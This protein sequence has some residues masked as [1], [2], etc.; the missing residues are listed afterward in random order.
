MKRTAPSPAQS[1]GLTS[2][3]A[4]KRLA[5]YGDNTIYKKKRLRPIVVFLEKFNSPLLIILIV[6]A[7]IAFFLGERVNSIIILLMVVLSAILDFVNSY[8]SEKAV[9]RLTSR[10]ATS[11]TVVRDGIPQE[12]DFSLLVPGDVIFLSAGDVVPADA[13][14]TQA[15]DF[16][17]NQATLTGE[18]FP[19]EKHPLS[20]TDHP[21]IFMG[22]SVVTGTATATVVMTG[23]MTEFGK[24]AKRLSQEAPESSFDTA[25][26]NFSYF[27]MKVTIVLVLLVFLIHIFLGH[28][29]FTT[30][31]FAVAIAV[32][33]TPE[34]LPVIISVSLSRG[35]MIMAKKDVIVK[36]LPAIQNF[37]SMNVLC[38]D[39]T[40]TLTEDKIVMVNYLDTFGEVY[41]PIL[42][43]SYITTALHSGIRSP[44]DTAIA[45]HKQFDIS[46]YTKIDEIPFDFERKRGSLVIEHDSKGILVT[47]GTPEDVL[48]ISTACER[49]G[50]NCAFSPDL[51]RAAHERYQQLSAEGYR[52]LA[53]ATREITLTEEVY[54]KDAEH[55]MTFLGFIIFLDPP[56]ATAAE[57]VR[58]LHELGVEIKI[59]TGDSD[60]LTKKIC[61]DIGL[62]VRGI[63]TGTDVAQMNDAELM[64][65]AT[66]T[67]IFARINPEQKERII[68]ALKRGGAV[69]GYL[70]DGIND[71][72]A[73]RAADV[74]ISVNNAVDVAKETASIILLRKSLRAL[75]DGVIEGRKTFHNTTKYILMGLSSNFGNMLSMTAVSLFI[76][77]LPMLPAQILLNNFLYDSSQITLPTDT[78]DATDIRMP[79]K[80]D[81]HF[82]KRFMLVFGL[83][84]TFFDFITFGFLFFVFKL[85]ESQFQTGWFIESLATQ[86]F[87]IYIIRTKKIPFLESAPG[88]LLFATTFAAVLIGWI[89]P[90]T[91]LG[92]Y[93]L[94]ESLPLQVI[95]GIVS[96]AVVYLIAVEFA[97][98]IFYRRMAAT[99]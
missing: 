57:A 68:L 77:F 6:A 23:S 90:F 58:D 99:S 60:I 51:V 27:I 45:E 18:S 69:V 98:R 93:F 73:L 81:I 17:V 8:R 61:L 62:P 13:E 22:T 87:V 53:V 11:A 33:I 46:A 56:K 74:S 80:W 96:I 21:I 15:E 70:G 24:I 47:K 72:P 71:A 1:T 7:I 39:K 75:R 79:P 92:D 9:S 19:V 63:V 54:T 50:A 48:S 40:G 78:V 95:I 43:Y 41:E 86:V 34:L 66:T 25:I 5:Q 52:V 76:P 3:E 2:S 44:L 97:K 26:K 91:S 42:F 28:T 55:D 67:T 65:R 16:F 85:S 32:G 94:F 30:F 36:H 88:P 89:I 84:S 31:L 49:S 59:L 4:R 10:V 38:T 37:G 12:I 35:S 14:V 29:M 64:H 82:L 20:T 83:I